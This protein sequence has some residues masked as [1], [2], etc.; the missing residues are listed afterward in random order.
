MI[1][2]LPGFKPKSTK[3]YFLF[4]VKQKKLN[5]FLDK[6]LHTRWICPFKSSIATPVFFI[7]KKNGSLQL[8]QDYWSLN[9]M[10]VKNKYPLLLI[11][12]LVA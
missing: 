11:S 12:K 7:K 6:N 4:P 9:S 3:I 1:E 2:L 10:I 5:A 8:V